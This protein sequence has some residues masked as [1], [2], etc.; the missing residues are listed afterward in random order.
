MHV[1]IMN[2]R[3]IETVGNIQIING[4]KYVCTSASTLR[5]LELRLRLLDNVARLG[6]RY[7]DNGQ[8]R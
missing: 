5:T 8:V 6:L 4:I 7:N 2:G 1:T 3:R